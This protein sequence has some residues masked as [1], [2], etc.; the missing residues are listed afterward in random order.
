[1]YFPII[2]NLI[3]IV[4][5]STLVLWPFFYY[6]KLYNLVMAKK[7]AFSFIIGTFFGLMAIVFHLLSPELASSVFSNSRILLVLYSGLLGGPIAILTSTSWIVFTRDF[8]GAITEL[9]YIMKWHTLLTGIFTALLAIYKPITLTNLHYYYLITLAH[10]SIVLGVSY[11]IYDIPIDSLYKFMVFFAV[12]YT[13]IFIIVQKYHQIS[14]KLRAAEHME[15]TDFLTGLPNNWAIE[16][17]LNELMAKQA[18]F[19]ILHIDIDHFKDFNAEHSYRVGDAVLREISSL[20]REVCNKE[21]LFVGRFDSDEFVI[22]I[23]NSNPASAV[24]FA[25]EV[26]QLVANKTFEIHD[27]E[28]H[29]T[30]S[31]I[32]SSY[33]N[34]GA[35]F[36]DLYRLS[37]QGIKALNEDQMNNVAHVNQL[38]LEG[39]LS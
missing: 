13:C 1:M 25:F 35:T 31:I 6:E 3:F 11:K 17:H 19:E 37:I 30:I 27:E 14:L 20:L 24:R 4:A 21:G 12:A 38:F 2:T 9:T 39:K 23:E 22:F 26:N 15:A 16:H 18:P 7:T 29:I 36:E 8:L 33:P 28:Y 32:G 10:F 5:F 34:N